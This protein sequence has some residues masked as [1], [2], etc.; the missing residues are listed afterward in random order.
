MVY[1]ISNEWYGIY[2]ALSYCPIPTLTSTVAGNPEPFSPHPET[3]WGLLLISLLD[4][5]FFLFLFFQ[6]SAEEILA[7]IDFVALQNLMRLFP[8]SPYLEILRTHSSYP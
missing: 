8:F 7:Y 2:T 1:T 6:I 4:F 5:F 3:F